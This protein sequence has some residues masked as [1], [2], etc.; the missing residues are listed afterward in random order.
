M[1][2]EKEKK[3]LEAM[4]QKFK[5]E[6]TDKHSTF[7]TL[8]GWRQS[9]RKIEYMETSKKIEEKRGFPSLNEEI[10]V[11]LGQRVLMPYSLSYT[12]YIVE[13]DDINYINNAAMQQ[14]W[15]DIKRTVII[16]LDM[17]HSVL[18][19]RLGKEVT[20]ETIN[21]YLETYNHTIPG[22]AVIQEHMAENNPA[23]T[24]DAYVKVFTGD[25][26]LA[27]EVDK[28]FLIDINDR[29][30]DDQAK[31][32]KDAIGKSLWQ[33]ARI[34]TI[35]V[36]CTDGAT[37]SRWAA[38][39]SSMAFISS[40]K[41]CAGEAPVSDF[42]YASK[43]AAVIN[44]G[45]AMPFRRVRGS[46]EPGGIPFGYIADM[47]QS[48]RVYPDDPVRATLESLTLGALIYDQIYFAIYMSGG[49]GFT[50]YSSA[51]YTDNILS[52][53]CYWGADYLKEKYGGFANVKPSMDEIEKITVDVADYAIS[54]Y[55][56]YPSVMEAHFGGSQRAA[57]IA[58]ACGATV[59]MATGSAE[60]AV[61]SW[62][63]AHLLHKE[64]AG[65]LGFYGYDLQ[66][67]CGA[68]NSLAYRGDEGLPFELRGPN[69]PN[70]TMNVGHLSA[71]AG[72]AAAP[73]AARGDAWC[74]SPLI[75]VAFADDTL[76]FDFANITKEFGRGGLR[77]FK[78]EGERTGTIAP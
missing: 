59:G 26:E 50:Q 18:E 4:R 13:P 10:G 64:E 53:Y 9:K 62:Y 3:F 75:R 35:A 74:L 52:D 78:P 61:N 21:W 28:R 11:P 51:V 5:E 15:D 43:H 77:E 44:M 8:G 12:D 46:N 39:Q 40:Y 19:K 16:G 14:C 17:A 68:A 63:L 20:P 66:D 30:P 45:T 33:V 38:M 37:T 49:L 58:A 67:Q 71:Y 47:T 2:V 29:F 41:L 7:Y 56:T 6:P 34:P 1:P 31:K 48:T 36:R 27:D 69:Y 60:A 76:S 65:R 72:F 25:D 73:H 32:L 70:Y 55:E 54:Q 57:V 42:T 22:G 23:V 24:G